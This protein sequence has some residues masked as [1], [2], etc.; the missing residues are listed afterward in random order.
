[1]N[2]SVPKKEGCQRGYTKRTKGIRDND[3]TDIIH[4]NITIII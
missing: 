2:I 3:W 1:M 4:D